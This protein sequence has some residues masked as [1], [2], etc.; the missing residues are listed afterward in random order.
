MHSNFYTPKIDKQ[1]VIREYTTS[2]GELNIFDE[3]D[4]EMEPLG[5]LPFSI[6]DGASGNESYTRLL[7][8]LD[9]SSM[10]N[11]QIYQQIDQY[12]SEHYQNLPLIKEKE[13]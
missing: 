8:H 6:F 13:L 5:A 2:T 4:T 10:T 7:E 1:I 11:L 9:V 3:S 12:C